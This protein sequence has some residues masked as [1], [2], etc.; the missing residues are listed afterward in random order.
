[1]SLASQVANYQ[2]RQ[3]IAAMI[4]A[5]LIVCRDKDDVR[6]TLQRHTAEELRKYMV[7]LRIP[8]QRTKAR[9]I[10]SILFNHHDGIRVVS[11]SVS[12]L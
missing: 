8:S 10:D 4:D 3:Q 6:L 1:M 7:Y 9:M 2:K 11:N 12:R 5:E